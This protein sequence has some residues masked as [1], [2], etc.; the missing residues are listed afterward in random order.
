MQCRVHLI[1]DLAL[2]QLAL[3]DTLAGVC[4]E[5]KLVSW[6][7]ITSYNSGTLSL[8]PGLPQRSQSPL[9]ISSWQPTSVFSLGSDTSIWALHPDPPLHISG[10]REAC[11]LLL[12]WEVLLSNDLC[13]EFSPFCLLSTY[14]SLPSEIPKLYPDPTC[15]RVSENVETCS[16]MVSSLG[17]KSPSWN[18]LSLVFCFALPHSE[19]LELPFLKFEVFC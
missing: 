18:Y 4:Q 7:S 13:S 10:G 6:A 17:C 1:S 11:E 19:K 9:R 16:F 5:A 3:A 2:L 8:F 14:C 12:S 15:E